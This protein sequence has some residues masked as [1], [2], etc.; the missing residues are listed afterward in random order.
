MSARL[1]DVAVKAGVST[2]TASLVLNNKPSKII[3]SE[4]TRQLVMQAARELNYRPNLIARAMARQQTSLVALV[5]G[6]VTSSFYPVIIAG[7][8]DV[9]EE[10]GFS[11]LLCNCKESLT[12]QEHHLITV[13][14]KMVDGVIMTPVLDTA[15][16]TISHAVDGDRPLVLACRVPLGCNFPSV[17][18]DNEEGGYAATRHLIDL[19]HRHIVYVSELTLTLTPQE[20]ILSEYYQRYVGYLRAMREVGLD[21]PQP[22]VLQNGIPTMKQAEW[23]I[24]ELLSLPASKRPTAIFASSDLAAIGAMRAAHRLGLRIPRDLSVVGFDDLPVADLVTPRLTT[25]AQPKYEIGSESGR[26]LLSLI[27]GR[28]VESKILSPYLV[29]RETTSA[30]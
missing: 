10:Q 7:V 21:Y 19:K 1:K 23:L 3:I 17:R 25:V 5:V 22:L 27:E 29:F 20:Q 16:E 13:N 8:S 26:I 11:I 6:D 14:S 4:A 30:R 9:L 18:V 15:A 2:A 12:D 28:P 24:S